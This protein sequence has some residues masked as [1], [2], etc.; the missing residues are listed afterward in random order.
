VNVAKFYGINPKD[1]KERDLQ[2]MNEELGK[3]RKQLPTP[4]IDPK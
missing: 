4:K 2:M 1:V 3:E